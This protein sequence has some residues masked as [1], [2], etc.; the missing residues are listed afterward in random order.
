MKKYCLFLLCFVLFSPAFSAEISQGRI[1]GEDAYTLP[2]WFK[3]SFLEIQEE[4]KEAKGNNKHV[5]LFM[6]I[7]R[8]PYCTRMLD[9]NFRSGDIQQFI[10]N[11][12]DVIALNIRGDREIQWDENSSYSEKTL[13]TELKVHFTPT[14]IFL[15]ANGQKVFQM[16]GYR[17]PA[18]F[19]HVLNYVN[20]KQ[21]L[22]MKLV[23]YVRQQDDSLYNLKPHPQ[24]QDMKDF[25]KFN[26]PLA[27][28][29][30]DISCADCDEF[31][32]EVLLHQDVLTEMQKFTV[33]RLDAFSTEPVIDVDG[34]KTTAEDWAS[35][36]NLDYRPGTV[37][38][39]EGK[40]ITRADGR[41][42]HFHY[43]ELLRY[44][45]GGFYQEYPTYLKYLGIRQK[46]LLDAGVDID[47]SM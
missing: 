43:K 5:M 16:N 11:N 14:L 9:E 41:L 32:K 1:L 4:V 40:E 44:V 21:Y 31:H 3:E 34:N 23:D 20:N 10:E 25:S 2:G 19:K 22:N 12:Y 36:L 38:F 29:F 27:I 33:V 39:N 42:Y 15:N 17:N 45:S 6:H 47:F 37:L 8:C 26:G 35:R 46:Q 13:A 28:I 24:Y 7:D 18:A 30:E